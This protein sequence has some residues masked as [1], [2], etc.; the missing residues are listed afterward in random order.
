MARERNVTMMVTLGR[1]RAVQTISAGSRRRGMFKRV[2]ICRM[3]DA[4]PPMKGPRSSRLFKRKELANVPDRAPYMSSAGPHRRRSGWCRSRIDP[5][6]DIAVL[7]FTGGTTGTPK[8]AMLTHANITGICSQALACD[9]G[10]SG[11][12]RSGFSRVLPF[13]HVFAMT[14]VMN[15]GCPSARNSAAAAARYQAADADPPQS[16]PDLLP[17]VPT[18]F[19]ALCNAAEAAAQADLGF[20]KFCVS[21]GAPIAAEAHGAFRA[22]LAGSPIL[23]GYGLSETSPVVSFNRAG[24]GQTR[25]RR[26]GRARHRDRN[27]RPGQPGSFFC[28]QAQPGE[29][30]VRGP[31]VMR[32]YYNRPGR[33]QPVSWTAR[34]APAMSAISTP[35]AICSSSTAS[36]TDH[37]RRLTMSIRA[38]SR[39]RPTS[40]P[41]CRMR[42]R[43]ALPDNIAARRRN[44]SLR[45]RCS[46]ARR[47]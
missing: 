47:A 27:P 33:P 36:R 23:E 2:I 35:M 1:R 43:S 10:C 30:C 39:K 45:S 4:L 38:L 16:P 25:H 40:I 21:G 28:R 34:F 42:W 24:R 37:L 31:Q 14:A 15:F 46:P 41:P 11:R 7:Q 19:T 26:P 8:A 17:G 3:A 22:H 6:Q 5:A 20:V 29:I 9:A 44:F 12:G 32:G 18:L 13:F